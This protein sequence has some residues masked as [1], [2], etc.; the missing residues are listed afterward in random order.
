MHSSIYRFVL[1]WAGCQA[2]VLSAQEWSRFQ[3][4]G[5]LSL[6]EKTN[7]KVNWSTKDIAWEIPLT[8][9]GQ[10][11]PVIHQRNL[12]V[13]SVSGEMKENLHIHAFDRVSGKLLWK[14]DD[15]NSQPEK[16][17]SYV[18]R[19]APSPVCGA[20]GVIAFFAGGDLIALTPEGQ[21]RWR[22]NLKADLG[23]IGVRHGVGGSLEQN[24]QHVFVWVERQEKPYVLAISKKTGETVWKADGLG[25]TSWSSPRLV[26]V[27]DSQHLV[28]SGIG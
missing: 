1:L 25:S 18:S 15:Q 27:G 16:N 26:S 12:Y 19:A 4:G 22:R 14:H 17:T 21:L 28:L 9:Y 20:E 2:A 7:L 11:S 23:A 13:T 3:N 10:S 5:K 8:G 6:G 24:Q